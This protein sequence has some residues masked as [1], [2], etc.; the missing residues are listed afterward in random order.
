ETIGS[1]AG[2]DTG[3]VTNTLGSWITLTAGGDDSSTTFA[4]VMEDGVGSLLFAKEGTGTLVLSGTNT[5]GN[6][7]TVSA[8][9]LTLTGS[10]GAIASSLGVTISEGAALMLDNTAVANN[11]DRLNDVGTVTMNGG[12]LNFSNNAGA[13]NYSET[14]GALTIGAGANTISS[15]Q[16]AL[17]QTSTLTFDSLAHTVGATVDFTGTGLG[18]DDRNQIL[19]TAPPTLGAWATYNGT[20]FAAYDGVNG[21]VAA[22]YDSNIANCNSTIADGSTNVRINFAG[23]PP[24]TTIALGANTTT[25]NTLLQNWTSAATVDTTGKTLSVDG[26]MI[27][28]GK[29]ALTIGTA[30]GD[31]TLTTA[32]P[33]GELTLINDS[34]NALTINAVIADNGGSSLIKSGTG[35]L[36]LTSTNAYTGLTTINGGILTLAASQTTNFNFGGD[37]TLELG[38]GFD[39]GGDVTTAKNGQGTLTLMGDNVINGNIGDGT[40]LSLSALNL[41]GGVGTTVEINGDVYTHDLTVGSGALNMTSG[42]SL[43]DLQ[44]LTNSGAITV[45]TGATAITMGSGDDTLDNQAGGTI[46]LTASGNGIEMGEGANTLTNDGTLEIINA[47][48]TAIRM[49]DGADTLTNN[50]ILEMGTVRQG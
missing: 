2:A 38:A 19:F 20:G 13:V 14:T 11:T 47:D 26:I 39:I 1:L 46:T 12:T 18:V 10:N 8:G 6:A 16:A 17:G 32:T 7:T 22:T 24:P 31:G 41:T 40:P 9:T 28:S 50:G 37:A 33:G 36:I 34:G 45:E 30:A 5:Y 27:N 49:G 23:A 42:G 15:S 48:G 25:I 21:V 44:N 35:T 4:G 29:A 3:L 43:Y